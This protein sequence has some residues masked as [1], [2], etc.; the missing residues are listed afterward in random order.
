MILKE[1]LDPR[2]RIALDV[3]GQLES[4]K[5]KAT[6]MVYLEPELEECGLNFGWKA[7]SHGIDESTTDVRTIVRAQ[8]SCRVCAL[9]AL[10][11]SKLDAVNGLSTEEMKY[12]GNPEMMYHYLSDFSLKELLM[13]ELA[14]EGEDM[15]D[16]IQHRSRSVSNLDMEVAVDFHERYHNPEERLRAI[17]RNIVENEGDF[18]P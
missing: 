14:F 8:K 2:V 17:M 9:G 12:P 6:S 5:I 10:F 11:V 3:L 13:I 15:Q 16:E 7:W 4:R 1:P 18:F